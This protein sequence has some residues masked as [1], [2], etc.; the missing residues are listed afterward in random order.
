MDKDVDVLVCLTSSETLKILYVIYLVVQ[1][2]RR[3]FF[4]FKTEII[5]MRLVKEAD[6]PPAVFGQL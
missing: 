5:G 2:F 3:S 1:F 6:K 4:I